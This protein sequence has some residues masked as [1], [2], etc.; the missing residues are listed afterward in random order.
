MSRG[1]VKLSTSIVPVT[2]A[3]SGVS[4]SLHISISQVPDAPFDITLS[5]TSPEACFL[6]KKTDTASGVF[7]GVCTVAQFLEY[8]ADS[9][10]DI[11]RSS[12]FVREYTDYNTPVSDQKAILERITTF[13][14]NLNTYVESYSD[15]SQTEKTFIIP[16]YTEERLNNLIG[17]WRSLK[18][19]ISSRESELSI[20]QDVQLPSLLTIKSMSDELQ[21]AANKLIGVDSV[22]VNQHTAF[23][24]ALSAMADIE[25]S[26]ETCEAQTKTNTSTSSDMLTKLTE[27]NSLLVSMFTDLTITTDVG[28]RVAD[29]IKKSVLSKVAAIQVTQNKLLDTNLMTLA[30]LKTAINKIKPIT[31]NLK[32]IAQNDFSEGETISAIKEAILNFSKVVVKQLAET[33]QS[34]EELTALIEAD[35][36]SLQVVEA[37][38][39]QIRPSI[40]L[41]NPESAWYFTV[42]IQ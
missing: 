9:G 28:I 36:S 25:V 30:S 42:N 6:Y 32:L 8:S 35:K 21:N 4:F 13:Y 20:K 5:G 40:D 16:D 38:M 34:I 3:A 2:N 10:N 18:L 37:Q 41:S 26:T 29:E 15:S 14:N 12:E 22:T 24:S 17:M 11:Y 39:K 19:R 27:L 23:N 33:N 7:Q 31:L 1:K